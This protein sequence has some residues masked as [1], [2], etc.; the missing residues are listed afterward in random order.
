MLQDTY[1]IYCKSIQGICVEQTNVLRFRLYNKGMKHLLYGNEIFG[2]INTSFG[3][4]EVTAPELL[5]GL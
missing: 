2:G 3:A 1:N 4:L 5:I